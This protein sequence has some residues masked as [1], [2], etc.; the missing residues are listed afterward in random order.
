MKRTLAATTALLL[1]LGLAGCRDPAPAMET[2]HNEKYGFSLSMEKEFMELFVVMEDLDSEY[3]GDVAFC[4]S[5]TGTS[6]GQGGPPDADPI[7]AP[8]ILEGI[9]FSI[10][11]EPAGG[12]PPDSRAQLLASNEQYSFYFLKDDGA[13]IPETMLRERFYQYEDKI[14]QIPATFSLDK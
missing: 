9:F 5:E 12:G 6:I 7:E 8:Y 14:D 1:L 10:F 13:S 4:Y 2:Y 3:L 11:A